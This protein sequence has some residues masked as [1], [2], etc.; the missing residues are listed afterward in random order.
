MTAGR[1]FKFTLLVS[2]VFVAG[3]SVEAFLNLRGRALCELN[4]CLIVGE[5]S[6]ISH[7]SMVLLGW[8]YFLSL[9]L[10]SLMA[11]RGIRWAPGALLFVV[12]AGLMG[13]VVF[14]LRQTLEYHLLCPFCIVVA[15]GVGLTALP[16]IFYHRR[17]HS[18]GTLAGVLLSFYLTSVSLSPLEK[19]MRP[20]FPERPPVNN[21][22]LIYSPD[23]PHCHEVLAFCQQLPE[24]NLNLCPKEE[25]V[26]LLRA[27]NL[28]GIPVLVVKEDP[29]RIKVLQGSGPIISYLR[30]RFPTSAQSPTLLP[31]TETEL[32]I[33]ET[34]GICSELQPKCE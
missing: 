24:A 13:E 11:L 29:L 1:L 30:K 31:P 14:L 15:L 12:S 26:S 8:G 10:L 7:Q 23:C 5:L 21:L 28:K 2:L 34:G 33:P 19:T 9:V 16:V 27:L 4:S 25:A 32:L 6:R 3:L 20:A 17:L 18:V 22:I